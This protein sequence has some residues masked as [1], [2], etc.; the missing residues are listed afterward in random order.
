MRLTNLE[1]V[2]FINSDEEYE[3]EIKMDIVIYFLKEIHFQKM[4]Q[5]DLPLW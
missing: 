3:D 5:K 1:S 2:R 4:Q